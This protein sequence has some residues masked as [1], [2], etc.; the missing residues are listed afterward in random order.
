MLACSSTATV[1]LEIPSTYPALNRGRRQRFS[2]KAHHFSSP[3]TGAY[4]GKISSRIYRLMFTFDSLLQVWEA[5]APKLI[6]G[7]KVKSARCVITFKQTSHSYR[8]ETQWARNLNVQLLGERHWHRYAATTQQRT[9]WGSFSRAG[10]VL[11]YLERQFSFVCRSL[12]L[13]Q[14]FAAGPGGQRCINH[15]K[16]TAGEAATK[17]QDLMS[18]AENSKRV[19]GG[20]DRALMHTEADSHS[21]APVQTFLSSFLLNK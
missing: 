1:T 8:P 21:A 3:L 13:K 12:A 11:S 6:S 18:S 5:K 19:S 15:M 20:V 17:G 14:V 7:H 10:A 4:P 16:P 2:T 9:V